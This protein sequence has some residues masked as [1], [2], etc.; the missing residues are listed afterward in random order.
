MNVCCVFCLCV[1]CC[2]L[3]LDLGA[4]EGGHAGIGEGV[5]GCC[6]VQL[7][8][9]AS[10]PGLLDFRISVSCADRC[11]CILRLDRD[12][13]LLRERDLALDLLRARLDPE[14]VSEP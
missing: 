5:G 4:G 12:R 7:T 10:G 3:T 8:F 13:A 14:W 1:G 11:C 9:G 2:V 6:P